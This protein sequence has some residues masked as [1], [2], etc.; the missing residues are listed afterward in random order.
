MINIWL[1]LL[2]LLLCKCI[3]LAKLNSL[4]TLPPLLL[5]Q[6]P[7]FFLPLFTLHLLCFS[8]SRLFG[9]RSLTVQWSCVRPQAWWS[10]VWR[11]SRRTT[12]VVSSRSE[13]LQVLPSFLF[14]GS[15][16]CQNLIHF[17]LSHFRK[18]KRAAR[19]SCF[20]PIK[21]SRRAKLEI[22]H[23]GRWES[24]VNMLHWAL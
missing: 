15:F 24:L 23:L 13:T 21:V 17:L 2:L 8:R 14:S 3:I 22:I 7:L 18:S 6:P 11:S 20:I 16:H 19:L 9:I 5:L 12:P 4:S 10:T 1:S